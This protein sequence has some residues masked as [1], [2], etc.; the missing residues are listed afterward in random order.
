MQ[1]IDVQH[2]HTDNIPYTK[3][4][5]VQYVNDLGNTGG[6]ALVVKGTCN[7][8]EVIIVIDQNEWN[9]TPV[10]FVGGY[11]QVVKTVETEKVFED[12]PD[13]LDYYFDKDTTFK[14]NRLN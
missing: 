6:G 14:V 5:L 12:L 1:Q 13:V 9:D 4:Q 8:E 2:I 10:C 11:G 7:N 3:Q